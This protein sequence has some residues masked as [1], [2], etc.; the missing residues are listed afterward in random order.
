MGLRDSARGRRSLEDVMRY[1]GFGF[2]IA[3]GSVVV[4]VRK[5]GRKPRRV[6]ALLVMAGVEGCFTKRR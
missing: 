4:P 6:D 2:G 3:S 1:C 5:D